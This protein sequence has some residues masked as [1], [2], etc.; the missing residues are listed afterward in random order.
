M[1][2]ER[3]PPTKALSRSGGGGSGGGNRGSSSGGSMVKAGDFAPPSWL[4]A[5]AQVPPAVAPGPRALLPFACALAG[6]QKSH[7]ARYK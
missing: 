5:G 4:A 2:L 1:L 6:R 3:L 7:K